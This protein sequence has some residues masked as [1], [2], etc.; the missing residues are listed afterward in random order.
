MYN[1][2]HQKTS[3]IV[4]Y[5]HCLKQKN[6]IK[7]KFFLKGFFP[8]D[9]FHPSLY[10][11]KKRTTFIISHLLP[12]KKIFIFQSKQYRK[13]FMPQGYERL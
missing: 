9:L 2:L 12:P 3:I 8:N 11:K 6:H 5:S 13:I 1:L 10:E 7:V 4:F